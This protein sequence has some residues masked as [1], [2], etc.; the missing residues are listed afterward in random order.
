MYPCP[1]EAVIK[2]MKPLKACTG[3]YEISNKDVKKHLIALKMWFKVVC[4]NIL[5][6]ASADS[7][8]NRW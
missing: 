7:T 3:Q 1:S 2:Y 6:T 4:E 5:C 8:L